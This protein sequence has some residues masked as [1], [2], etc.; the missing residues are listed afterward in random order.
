MK[1]IIDNVDKILGIIC[2]LSSIVT[3]Y[4][5]GFLVGRYD[6]WLELYSSF[7]FACFSID[8]IGGK[9]YENYST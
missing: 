4:M 6:K 2:I 9:S 5:W 7:L 8:I 1:K 3:G